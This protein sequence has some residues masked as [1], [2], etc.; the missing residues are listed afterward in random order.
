MTVRRQ[1]APAAFALALALDPAAWGD[2]ATPGAAIPGATARAAVDAARGDS[3]VEF[4][5]SDQFGRVHDAS[6]YRGRALVVVGAGRAGRADG[7]A[8]VESLRALQADTAEAGAHP[9]VAVADLRGVPRLLRRVVR[10]RFPDERSRAVLLDW[11]GSVARRHGFDSERCTILV[12]GPTG[13]VHVQT[14]T[15]AV[16]TALARTILR[17]ATELTAPLPSASRR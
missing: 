4:R 15:A 8:W 7:T 14:T 1:L 16:D 6:T 2:A 3:V 9:V 12:V 11:D 10:G 17:Q 5:L 13:R